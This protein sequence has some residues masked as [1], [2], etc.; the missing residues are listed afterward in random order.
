MN[1]GAQFRA[2]AGL[3][4]HRQPGVERFIQAQGVA[5]AILGGRADVRQ[6]R[7]FARS[8]GPAQPRRLA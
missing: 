4:E 1:G 3:A 8:Q 7:E 5:Q 6:R 2:L